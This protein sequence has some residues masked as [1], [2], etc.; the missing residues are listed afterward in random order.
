ME[1]TLY[2]ATGAFAGL[3]AGLLGVGGGLVI[4]PVLL[5]VFHGQGID[6]AVSMHLAVGSSLATIV[7]TSLSSIHSH[8]RR[9]A[10][11]WS[12][13]KLLAP[14][15]VAGVALGTLAANFLP[16][17]WLQRVFGVFAVLVAAQLLSGRGFRGDRSMPSASAM[18]VAGT[19]TGG[20]SALVGIGGGS[21]TV[22]FLA[23][24]GMPM[25][26]AVATSSACGLPI[27]AAGALG[28]AYIGW[29]V[30]QLPA[31]ATGFVFWPA[32]VGILVASVATAP[33]GARLAH[34]L[35]VGTLKRLFGLLLLVVGVTLL[36]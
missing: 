17:Q 18:A 14:G 7:A 28:F 6:G 15:L 31:G 9:G 1:W 29:R 30:P 11:E 3:L 19:F 12:T 35:P 34:S 2:L 22:P 32:V 13:V 23:W 16:S 8:H 10:V 33:L 21:L 26:R 36:I 27:A 4:V 20:I 25:V 5:W 24:H